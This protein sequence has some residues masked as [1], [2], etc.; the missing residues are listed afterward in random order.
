[1]VSGLNYNRGLNRDFFAH[2]TISGNVDGI[3]IRGVYLEN[4]GITA[5]GM[6]ER[7][8]LG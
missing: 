7:K 1:M 8:P 4:D 5:I 2:L 6:E 3:N